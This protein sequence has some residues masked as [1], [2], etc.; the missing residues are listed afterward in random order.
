MFSNELREVSW[1]A[2]KGKKKETCLYR[3]RRKTGTEKGSPL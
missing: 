2:P 1:R 3:I